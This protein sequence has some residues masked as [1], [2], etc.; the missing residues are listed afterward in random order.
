[1]YYRGLCWW[2]Y[3]L[4]SFKETFKAGASLYGVSVTSDSSILQY[5][6]LKIIVICLIILPWDR[7]H[8]FLTCH[9][10]TLFGYW[11]MSLVFTS[12]TKTNKIKNAVNNLFFF[13]YLNILLVINFNNPFK[14]LI[15]KIVHIPFSAILFSKS[16]NVLITLT[17]NKSLIIRCPYNGIYFPIGVSNR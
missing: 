8:E 4:S 12:L 6:F 11:S 17:K 1:M 13:S 3:H 14:L 2:V 7:V 10:F 16:R 5:I 9:Q 15:D